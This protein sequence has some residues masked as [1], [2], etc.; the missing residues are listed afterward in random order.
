MGD[1]SRSVYA[2][3]VLRLPKCATA[4]D[5]ADVMLAAIANGRRVRVGAEPDWEATDIQVKSRQVLATDVGRLVHSGDGT[6]SWR[7]PVRTYTQRL[8]RLT[9]QIV[10]AVRAGVTPPDY[11]LASMEELDSRARP[12]TTAG[13]RVKR[14]FLGTAAALAELGL[15]ALPASMEE[16]DSRARS[17]VSMHNPNEEVEAQ[18]KIQA[19]FA[20]RSKIQEIFNA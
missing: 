15:A 13:G 20:A 16:L 12:L 6:W 3:Q 1:D 2:W 17:L 11:D 8:E 9:E 10:A 5:R 14:K 4:A 18:R 7:T 19:I